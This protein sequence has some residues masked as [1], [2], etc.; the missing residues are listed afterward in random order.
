MKDGN[1]RID[2]GFITQDIE[3]LIGT[4][5]NVLGVGGT[6]ERMLSLR[7]TD[8]IAPIVKAIQEQQVVIEKQQALIDALTSRLQAVETKLLTLP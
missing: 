6:E 1:D 3:T 2:F 8:F 7:Y 4:N 5:D